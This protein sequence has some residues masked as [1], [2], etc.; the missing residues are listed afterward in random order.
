MMCM[1]Q[2]VTV[3]NVC[4]RDATVFSKEVFPGHLVKHNGYTLH[5]MSRKRVYGYCVAFFF[6]FLLDLFVC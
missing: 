4:Y 1:G 3:R 2:A 5:F 6:F